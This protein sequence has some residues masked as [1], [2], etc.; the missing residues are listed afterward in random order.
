MRVA[1]ME[2]PEGLVADSHAWDV[3]ARAI[4]EAEPDVLVT[5]EMPFGMWLARTDAFDPVRAAASVAAHEAGLEALRRLNVPVVLSSRP[6]NASGSG[7][8]VNEAFALVQGSYRFAHHK[9]YFPAEPGWHETSWFAPG[10]PG[11]DVVDAGAF[12]VGFLLCTELFFNEWARH[13]GR[14][15]ACLIAAPRAT[16]ESIDAWLTAGSMAAIV[17]G[18]FVASSN[19]VGRV[20]S[21]PTFGGGGFAFAPDGTLIASTSANEPVIAFDM[22]PACSVEQ[23]K[24]YPCY[25]PEIADRGHC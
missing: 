5:D 23:Q 21:G 10:K 7:Q 17:S 20:L 24:R 14:R 8:L 1:I 11:F 9:H 19:R 12:G 3:I 4:H 6:V 18:C 2:C 15:G 22:D 16:G 13:Y 25:V